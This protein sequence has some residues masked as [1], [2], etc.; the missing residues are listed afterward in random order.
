MLSTSRVF[1]TLLLYLYQI[2]S[3]TSPNADKEM[4]SVQGDI[5]EESG[6]IKNYFYR[7]CILNI[8]YFYLIFTMIIYNGEEL[9]SYVDICLV[10]ASTVGFILRMLCYY[11]LGHMFTYN[12]GIRQNHKLIKT[13]PY[14]L[15]IHPS[16]TGQML[17][18]LSALLFLRAYILVT[19]SLLYVYQMVKDRVWLEEKIMLKK[20]G[21]EYKEYIAT[22]WRFIPYVY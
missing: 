10:C 4:G 16:Y 14:S 18:L 19:I 5:T 9:L 7:S 2:L 17:S 20:F 13:G 22:R 15:L 3:H 1:V 6:K 8:S 12:L 21:D 11:E